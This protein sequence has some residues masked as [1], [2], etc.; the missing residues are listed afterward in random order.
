MSVDFWKTVFDWASV[1]L[2]GLTFI[3]GAGAL[4]TGRILNDRQ[5]MRLQQ[6]NEV[7]TKAETDLET[8]KG[9]TAKAQQEAS[10]AALALAKFKA[11]RAIP[12]EREEAFVASLKPF[13]GQNFA[14]AT[15]PD[16]EALALSRTLDALL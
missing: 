13:A 8:Q 4:I 16:P 11:P 2:V 10:E 14:L 3:A 9:L 15:F 12:P 1:V 6:M 5:S 7:L